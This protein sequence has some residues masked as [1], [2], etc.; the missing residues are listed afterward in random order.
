MY[1]FPAPDNR[2]FQKTSSTDFVA[3]ISGRETGYYKNIK[4]FWTF[5]RNR[6]LRHIFHMR[7]EVH[8]LLC[9]LL[10]V[11]GCQLSLWRL[12]FVTG[13]STSPPESSHLQQKFPRRLLCHQ[14]QQ[15]VPAHWL[16]HFA[17]L[18]DLRRTCQRYSAGTELPVC[19]FLNNWLFPFVFAETI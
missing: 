8:R 12:L 13:V 15:T 7:R 10:S 11:S 2:Y 14:N 3:G 5:L 1:V 4:Y 6:R 16:R 9:W 17:M 18:I 19:L